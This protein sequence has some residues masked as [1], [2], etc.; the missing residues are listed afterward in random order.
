M[1]NG[2]LTV[3]RMVPPTYEEMFKEAQAWGYDS[4]EEFFEAIKRAEEESESEA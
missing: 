4:V 2:D 3:E 1:F